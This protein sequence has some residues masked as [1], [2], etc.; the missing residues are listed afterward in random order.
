MMNVQRNIEIMVAEYREQ[1]AVLSERCVQYAITAS[2]SAERVGQLEA[3][4]A[5]MKAEKPKK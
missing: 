4:I 3:E 1:I 2:N 5:A